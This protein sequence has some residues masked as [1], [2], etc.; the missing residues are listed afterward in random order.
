MDSSPGARAPH[1][2]LDVHLPSAPASLL[3]R[4]DALLDGYDPFA[5]HEAGDGDDAAAPDDERRATPL[6]RRV[7]FFSAG[8]RDA[9]RR[10]RSPEA[11]A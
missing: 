6:E 10:F 1:P 2:A 9:A 11:I 4:L 3:P 7:Y 5:I 8:S